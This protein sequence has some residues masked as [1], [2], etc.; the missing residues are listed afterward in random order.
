M[1]RLKVIINSDEGC[2]APDE[3]FKKEIKKAVAAVLESEGIKKSCVTYVTFVGSDEIRRL[4]R[5]YMKKNRVTDVL[6]FPSVAD[7][8][9]ISPFDYE[10]FEEGSRSVKYLNLGD[11]ILYEGAIV[12]HAK[13]FKDVFGNG[14]ENSFENET[15]YMVIHS[16]L[17]L[18]G[19]DHVTSEED[20]KIMTDKQNEIFFKLKN[21]K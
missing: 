13:E 11:M 2:F 19:Y 21:I 6:S 16:T 15:I 14:L 20:N 8:D 7:F 4:N 3:R 17:H 18:L 1:G 5:K 12:R 10:Y 9:N